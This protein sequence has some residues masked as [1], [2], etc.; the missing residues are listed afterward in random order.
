MAFGWS[1]FVALH[2]EYL[3]STQFMVIV[4]VFALLQQRKTL[5]TE[6]PLKSPIKQHEI[7]DLCGKP[8]T[9]L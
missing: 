3:P 9:A 2:W 8:Q 5:K 7:L 4:L 6:K 1:L